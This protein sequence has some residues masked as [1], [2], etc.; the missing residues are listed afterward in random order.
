MWRRPALQSGRALA[1]RP[2]GRLLALSTYPAGPAASAACTRAALPK[3]V[4]TTTSTP[5]ALP[6]R[7]VLHDAVHP[8]QHEVHEHDVGEEPWGAAPA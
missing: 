8:A 1:H 5:G 2:Q 3:L 6:Q 4:T 7:R